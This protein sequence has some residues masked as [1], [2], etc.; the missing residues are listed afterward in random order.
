MARSG[1]RVNAGANHDDRRDLHDRHTED[2]FN[3]SGSRTLLRPRLSLR[4]VVVDK[5]GGLPIHG[6]TGHENGG[7]KR[8][9]A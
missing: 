4:K 3:V 7:R 9:A 1:R 6:L 5:L 2:F 8:R